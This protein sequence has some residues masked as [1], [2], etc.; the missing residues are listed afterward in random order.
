VIKSL[1][2]PAYGVFLRQ[3]ARSAADLGG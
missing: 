2:A 3:M 1:C